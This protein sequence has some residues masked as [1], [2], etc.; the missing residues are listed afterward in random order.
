MRYLDRSL[1]AGRVLPIS[2]PE[3][4]N[5]RTKDYARHD[6]HLPAGDCWRIAAAAGLFRYKI[7]N[8][9]SRVTDGG[10]KRP[11]EPRVHVPTWA[12]AFARRQ[13]FN[14]DPIFQHNIRGGK[15]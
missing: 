1:V 10:A 5:H 9:A 11:R 4:V 6:G 15:N 14:A 3:T 7:P 8:E 2:A 13:Q 12:P